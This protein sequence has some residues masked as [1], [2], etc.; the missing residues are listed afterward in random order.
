MGDRPHGGCRSQ[1]DPSSRIGPGCLGVLS[2]QG[3]TLPQ[4]RGIGN[5]SPEGSVNFLNILALPFAPH[6]H[7]PRSCVPSWLWLVWGGWSWT[8]EVGS[9]VRSK[10]E[11]QDQCTVPS[12]SPCGRWCGPGSFWEPRGV[13]VGEGGE[14]KIRSQLHSTAHPLVGQRRTLGHFPK[15]IVSVFHG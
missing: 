4:V 3:D 12:V 14:S 1:L 6:L 11:T 10:C 7:I 8:P 5:V 9:L 13:G 15:L 2:G